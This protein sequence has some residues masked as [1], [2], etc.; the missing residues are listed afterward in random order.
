M[1][2]YI[3]ITLLLSFSFTFSN[4]NIFENSY[5]LYGVSNLTDQA[6]IRS[7]SGD[8]YFFGISQGNLIA[9]KKAVNSSYFDTYYLDFGLFDI[10]IIHGVKSVNFSNDNNILLIHCRS[11]STNYILLFRFINNSLVLVRDIYQ[12]DSIIKFKSIKLLF[13]EA[14][15]IIYEKSKIILLNYYL[16]KDEVLKNSI[17]IDGD[18]E[19][20]IVYTDVAYNINISLILRDKKSYQLWHFYIHN[21]EVVSKY[22]KE[23][24]INDIKSF[25]IIQTTPKILLY[26]E[27][28]ELSTYYYFKNKGLM[29]FEVDN[30]SKEGLNYYSNRLNNYLALYSGEK[31]FS[32]DT[33]EELDPD[34]YIIDSSIKYAFEDIKIT[35]TGEIISVE[36]NTQSYQIDTSVIN[37]YF[38]LNKFLF[39]IKDSGISKTLSLNYL[40]KEGIVNFSE[41]E[42][43]NFVLNSGL[44]DY[45]PGLFILPIENLYI[46]EKNW[47]YLFSDHPPII[48]D[49]YILFSIA[50]VKYIGAL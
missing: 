29:Y 2:Y 43:N 49:N 19:K 10:D 30:Y 25:S 18:Y 39:T 47:D 44:L 32:L 45:K 40:S 11:N 42:M 14:I 26:S 16:N 9:K 33:F 34:Q 12:S 46:I 28:K 3:F 15:F 4:E 13:D 41:I 37:N 20:D 31:L 36:S 48:F 21:K 1:K 6:M 38:L 50:N 35:S 7:R 22:I 23:M 24:P 5:E 17:P 27:D 8:D